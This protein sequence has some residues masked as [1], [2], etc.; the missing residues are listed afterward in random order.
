MEDEEGIR[1]IFKEGRRVVMPAGRIFVAFYRLSP[2]LEEFQQKVGLLRNHRLGQRETLEI[3]RLNPLQMMRW[4][5]AKANL[6][7]PATAMLMMGVMARST[8]G[9]KR[10]TFRMQKLFRNAE[11]AEALLGASPEWI[12]YRNEEEI[13]NLFEPLA[14][15]VKRLQALPGCVVV[16]I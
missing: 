1:T 3:Y 12:P 4:V 7:L 14:I 6:S 9:E 11:A 10:M 2:V 13:R 5:A 16:Q 15:P 8:L